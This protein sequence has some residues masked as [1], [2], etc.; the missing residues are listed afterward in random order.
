MIIKILQRVVELD[1]MSLKN[2]GL[3]VGLSLFFS[4]LH[5]LKS[6]LLATVFIRI[7][8]TF[9]WMYNLQIHGSPDFQ[10]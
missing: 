7:M 4:S 9:T 10:I 3:A 1:D 5:S 8:I 2:Y 6:F